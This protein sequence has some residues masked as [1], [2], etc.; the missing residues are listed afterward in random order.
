[1]QIQ[2]MRPHKFS[3]GVG[4]NNTSLMR[5]LS[6]ILRE[7][8]LLALW[9][10][11]GAMIVHRFPY[12]ALTFMGNTVFRTKLDS[13]PSS[14]SIPEQVRA[15]VAGSGSAG[16]ALVACYPLDVIKTRLMAQTKTQYYKGI[17]DALWKVPHQEG[18][19]GLYRGLGVSIASV[20]PS[21][22]VNFALYG[23]FHTL[24]SGLDLPPFV[25][26]L[27][28]GGCSGAASATLL[29]PMDLLRR[30]MQMVGLGGRPMVY[31]NV[32]QALRH[33][34]QIGWR[35]HEGSWFRLAWGFREFFRG[36][37][38]ELAK[39]IPHNAIMFGVHGHL[40]TMSWPHEEATRR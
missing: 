1:M 20:V 3:D 29:F 8:G 11:N 32:W 17:L 36:L 4:P 22:G 27:L 28:S 34:F 30:Q 39:V 14:S 18:L 38:P 12:T 6:K 2:S 10:G 31:S 23:E 40:L 19:R 24:Y 21:L 7:E 35:H 15:L 9:R 25:L 5:S 37:A 26:S 33:V 16:I 13:L